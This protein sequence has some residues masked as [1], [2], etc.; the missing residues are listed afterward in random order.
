MPV[1]IPAPNKAADLARCHP[2]I[3]DPYSSNRRLLRDMLNDLG[4]GSVESC[5]DIPEAWDLL[6]RGA[7][8]LLFLDWSDATDALGFLRVLRRPNNPLRFLPV[9]VITGAGDLDHVRAGRDAGA[10]EFMLRP[11]SREVLASRLRS[12]TQSPRLFVQSE[13]FFGPDRRRRRVDFNGPDR[14]S[15]AN[16]RADRRQREETWPGLERRQG[17]PGFET[18]D[19]RTRPRH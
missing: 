16:W 8:N 4:V 1:V 13:D 10:T 19:R 2:L 6:C 9:V 7:N 3:V 18:V 15:H 14:R 5:I 11:F 12:I 17:Q